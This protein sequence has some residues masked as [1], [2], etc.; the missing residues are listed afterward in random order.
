MKKKILKDFDAQK[1]IVSLLITCLGLTLFGLYKLPWPQSL[2]WES[3]NTAVVFFGTI[4]VLI[5]LTC[6]LSWKLKIN[7]TFSGFLIAVLIAI[8]AGDIWPFCVAIWFAVASTLLGYLLCN[9]FKL[10]EISW[11][12]CFLIGAGVYGTVT[13]L[14]AHYSV[15]NSGVYSFALL[16]PVILGRKVFL[17]KNNYLLFRKKINQVNINLLDLA[18]VALG[19][20]YFMVSLMPEVGY[21][22]LASHLVVPT[23]LSFRYQWDFDV[24]KYVWAVMPMQADW[25]FS[26]GYM[27]AGETASRLINVGFI[28]LLVNMVRT[29]TIWAGGSLVGARWGSLIFLS[30]PLTFTEGSSLFVESI[31]TAFVISA[32]MLI[33]NVCTN[34]N[35]KLRTELPLVGVLLGFALATKALTLTILPGLLCFFIWNHKVWFKK[36]LFRSLGL[37][38]GFLLLLGGIPYFTAW[39]ITGNPLFPLYNKIFKSPYFTTSVDF[40]NASYN[41]GLSWDIIYRIT[42]ESGKYL[43]SIAGASGFHWLLLLIPT[44]FS[45]IVAP[46]CK[47]NWLLFIGFTAFAITFYSQSYLRYV[48]PSSLIFAVLIGVVISYQIMTKNLIKHIWIGLCVLTICLNLLFIN[49]GAQYKDFPIV[50]V[51]SQEKRYDYLSTKLP[52]KHAINFVNNLNLNN[53]P[54]AVFAE[55]LISGLSVDVFYANWYNKTFQTEIETLQTEQQFVNLLLK[56][57]IHYIILD[58]NWNGLNC[59]HAGP[60]KQEIIEKATETVATFGLFTV[61]KIKNEFL[62][63]KE[64]PISAGKYITELLSNSNFES[65]KSWAYTP[66]A[67]DSIGKVVLVSSTTPITEKVS[68]TPGIKYLL[69]GVARCYKQSTLGRLQINWGDGKQQSISNDLKTFECTSTWKEWDLEVTAPKDAAYGEVYVVGQTSTPIEYKSVSLRK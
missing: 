27:L 29:L 57:N 36:E 48:F 61:R 37:G 40:N 42:F 4:F 69:T 54:I 44:L 14:L 7:L 23:H 21:D 39:K 16:V 41:S 45:L 12:N 49:S 58:S 34:I 8:T 13:G 26:I 20:V 68:V 30:S 9:L 46:K 65:L 67:Y 51:F 56:R 52:I 47:T 59:C 11:I 31:W 60:Y 18:I 5:A 1:I 32:T 38:I 33:L 50:T 64:L 25:I 63:K 66:I 53:E 55:P 15:N 43:E 10:E 62:L 2:A 35:G 24:A 3:M 28:L 22:A 6:T 17:D 19:L